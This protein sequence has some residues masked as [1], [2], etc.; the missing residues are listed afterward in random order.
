MRIRNYGFVKE[1]K[2]VIYKTYPSNI[3]MNRPEVRGDP[4]VDNSDTT[5]RT[6]TTIESI[7]L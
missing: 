1:N 5:V 6:H 4:S 2:W 3:L 7:I